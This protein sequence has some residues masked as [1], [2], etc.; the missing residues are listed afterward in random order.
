MEILK[1]ILYCLGGFIAIMSILGMTYAPISLFIEH[2][3]K[4]RRGR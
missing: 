4:Q 3:L 2:I 1:F